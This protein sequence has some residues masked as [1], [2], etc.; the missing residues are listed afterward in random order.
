MSTRIEYLATLL[1]PELVDSAVYISAKGV[2]SGRYGVERTRHTQPRYNAATCDCGAVQSEQEYC[3]NRQ[4]RQSSAIGTWD[5]P[6]K[7]Q[8]RAGQGL[9][10]S[11]NSDC[12][13]TTAVPL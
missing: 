13:L 8:D 7:P 10:I 2:L 4:S 11:I 6:I 5:G 1:Q 12:D 3:V 9:R